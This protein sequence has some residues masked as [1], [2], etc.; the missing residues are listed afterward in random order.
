[1]IALGVDPGRYKTAYALIQH[2]NPNKILVV[3]SVPNQQVLPTLQTQ[4]SLHQ[5]RVALV[6]RPFKRKKHINGEDLAYLF[7]LAS[8]IENWLSARGIKTFAIQ[9]SHPKAWIDEESPLGWRQML[10]GLRYSSEED[11]WHYLFNLKKQGGLVGYIP[12]NRN[13]V[14]ALGMALCVG[15][16]GREGQQ[17]A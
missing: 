10:T 3:G 1:M 11:I 15:E 16:L 5:P 14:D 6:E 17:V 12:R 2:G 13:Q 7:N 4:L 9:A 8:Q